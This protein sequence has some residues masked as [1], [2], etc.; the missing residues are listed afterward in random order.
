[1]KNSIS[2]TTEHPDYNIIN[3]LPTESTI[4]TTHNR[5]LTDLNDNK[6]N[7]LSTDGIIQEEGY[8]IFY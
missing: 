6:P 1:M 5:I 8:W 4:A 3:N 7:Y 2:S